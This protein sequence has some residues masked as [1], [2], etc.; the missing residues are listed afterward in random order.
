[1][2]SDHTRELA[3]SRIPVSMVDMR[4]RR[5]PNKVVRRAAIHENHQELSD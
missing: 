3:L 2:R 4:H 1:M 5:V